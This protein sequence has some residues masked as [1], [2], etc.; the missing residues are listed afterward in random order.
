MRR[1]ISILMILLF[2]LGPLTALL[3]ASADDSRLPPCCRRHGAHH[4]AMSMRMASLMSQA[5]SGGKP[6]F[7]AP[8][9]CPLYPGVLSDSTMTIEAIAAPPVSLPT[10]LAQPHSPAASRAAARAS[11]IR[12]RAG[13]GPPAFALA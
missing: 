1:G 3:P 2:W 11:Q 9:T 13:R 4:C 12:T 8:M 10:L 7:A 6:V 5:T